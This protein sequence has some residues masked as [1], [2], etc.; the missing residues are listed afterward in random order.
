MSGGT[1]NLVQIN[2]NATAA[3]RLDYQV[4][5]VANVTGGTLNVG[6]AATTGNAGNFDFRIR[7]QV[8]NLVIDNTTNAK[9]VLLA[10]QTNT[11]LNTTIP[12]GSTL[13]AQSFIWLVV[14]N[15]VTN[16]GTITVPTSGGRFYFLGTGSNAQTYTGN[17]TCTIVTAAGSVDLTMD[18]PLGLTIDP[19]SGGIVTQ[20]VNFFR[21]GITN[22]NKVTLGNGGVTVG[23]L[24]YGLTASTNIAG[25]FDVAPVFNIGSG[26]QTILWAQERAARTTSV[27]IPASRTINNATVNNTNGVVLAG[28]NLTLN[29]TLTFTVGNLTTNANT[30]IIGGAGTVARTSGHVIGNLR[31]VYTAAASKTFEVGTANGFSSVVVNVHGGDVPRRFHRLGHAGPDAANLRHERSAKVLDA[32]EQHHRQRRQPDLQLSRDRRGRDGGQLRLRQEQRRH[33]D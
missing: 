15:T 7:G 26:G 23:V 32:L 2:S 13:N 20:R 1:I 17:G 3:N 28:G 25:N 31:K 4:S 30:L 27:E 5:S 8:P 24:Q 16:N 19:G 9:N 10:A 11:L 18:N 33:A 22:S 12:A 21:G 6:T 14:G 29:G